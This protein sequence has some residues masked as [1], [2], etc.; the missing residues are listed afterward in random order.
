MFF[1]FVVKGWTRLNFIR[2]CSRVFCEVV[3]WKKRIWGSNPDFRYIQCFVVNV[4][5]RSDHDEE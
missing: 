5:G 1:D 4:F 3:Q 2:H